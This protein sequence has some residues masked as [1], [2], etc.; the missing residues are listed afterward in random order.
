MVLIG[1][2]LSHVNSLPGAE[3]ND[4]KGKK[5]GKRIFVFFFRIIFL[6]LY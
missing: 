1:D 2:D 6:F 5:C 4:I 3:N